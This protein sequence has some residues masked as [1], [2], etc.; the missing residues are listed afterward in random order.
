MGARDL[1]RGKREQF[2]GWGMYDH[3]AICVGC[4]KRHLIP[5]G[6]QINYRPWLDWLVKHPDPVCETFILPY[7]LLSQL[8][9]LVAQLT[10]NADAKVAYGGSASYTI[11]LTGLA[12]SSSLLAGRASS[13]VSNGTDKY[14][15]YLVAGEIR[16]HEAT[17]VTVNTQIEVHVVGSLDD[18]PTWPKVAASGVA[19]SGT[20]EAITFL[21]GGIKAAVCKPVGLMQVDATT[22][23]RPYPFAPLGIRQSIGDAVSVSHLLFVTQSTGQALG[24]TAAN[25]FLKRTPVYATVS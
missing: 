25:H 14:I 18:T 12:S 20:D 1:F 24:A 13:A 5:K 23:N 4:G 7:S 16:N 8:D 2:E 15:D 9:A 6:E 11:T 10:H 3:V 21:S 17:A 22:A 19:F